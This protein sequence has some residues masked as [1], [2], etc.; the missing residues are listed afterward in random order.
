M[1]A[2]KQRRKRPGGHIR[3]SV[4]KS[5]LKHG[6]LGAKKVVVVYRNGVPSK[7]MGYAEHQKM[8][9]LP[10]K[11]KPWEHRK[12]R[13]TVPDPLGAVEGKVLGPLSRET[14]YE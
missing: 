3:R 13:A 10:K 1:P 11:V 6:A 5:L 9:E 12:P 4:S 7:V 2:R 8:V 14:I